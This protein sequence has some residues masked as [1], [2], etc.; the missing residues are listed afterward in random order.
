MLE[1]AVG[2]LSSR[3]SQVPILVRVWKGWLGRRGCLPEENNQ[4]RVEGD[5]RRGAWRFLGG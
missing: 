5:S 1:R 3:E 4:S 2:K